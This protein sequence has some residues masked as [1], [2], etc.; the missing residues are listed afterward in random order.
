VIPKRLTRPKVGL[1]P[2]VP[3]TEA[4]IR[5]E[6]EVSV[7]IAPKQTPAATAAPS[8]RLIRLESGSFPTDCASW[9]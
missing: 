4:G 2:T 8:H 9:V 7:P 3:H 6:P 5:M 1:R